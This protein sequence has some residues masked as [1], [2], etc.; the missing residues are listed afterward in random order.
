MKIFG[1]FGPVEL[2]IIIVIIAV[3]CGPSLFKKLGGRAKA[4]GKAAKK[5]IESGATNAGVDVEQAKKDNEGKSALDILGE[6]QDKVDEKMESRKEL[7][8]EE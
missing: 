5:G 6:F 1:L 3:L 2:V 7:D 8:I 4:V